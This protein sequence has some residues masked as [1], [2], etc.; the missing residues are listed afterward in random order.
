MM[1]P[2]PPLSSCISAVPSP[3]RFPADSILSILDL[4]HCSSAHALAIGIARSRRPHPFHSHSS[5]LCLSPCSLASALFDALALSS[6]SYMD[7][8]PV[9]AYVSV[10][11]CS[12]EAAGLFQVPPLPGSA[13]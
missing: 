12:V 8:R 5:S 9:L 7:N 4:A 10:P 3:L 11:P 2:D 6:S 1:L 13:L